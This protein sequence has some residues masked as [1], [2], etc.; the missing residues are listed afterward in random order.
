MGCSLTETKDRALRCY[1]KAGFRFVSGIA[2]S[3]GKK[4]LRAWSEWQKL[5]KAPA[6]SCCPHKINMK[7]NSLDQRKGHISSM[8]LGS[9]L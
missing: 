2:A 7:L 6:R 4:R 3:W 1:E 9:L 5:R 8:F